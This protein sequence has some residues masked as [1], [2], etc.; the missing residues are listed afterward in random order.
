MAALFLP[1]P[2]TPY[3]ERI[4]DSCIEMKTLSVSFGAVLNSKRCEDIDTIDPSRDPEFLH[5]LS[6]DEILTVLKEAVTWGLA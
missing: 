4:I 1:W 6:T 2:A 5:I 3:V